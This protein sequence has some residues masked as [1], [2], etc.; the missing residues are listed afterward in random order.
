MNTFQG[1]RVGLIDL[2]RSA[3]VE[4]CQDEQLVRSVRSAP[5]SGLVVEFG[6]W[7]G[8]T[9]NIIAEAIAPR[10]LWGFDSFEGL[11]ENWDRGSGVYKAGHFGLQG[12]TPAVLPNVRLVKGW[13]KDTIPGFLDEHPG[14]VAFI[15][16]DSDLKSSAETI[17][18]LLNDRIVPGTVIRFDEIVDWTGRIYPNWRKG[19][20]LALEEWLEKGRRVRALSRTDFQ[21]ATVVV[22]A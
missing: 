11:P 6:V 9:A 15:H 16:V 2:L 4:S 14:P 3:P 13:F 20:Y 18:N 12:N 10:V 21:Q 7:R 1:P 5:Q 8:N 17:L 22:E 19:E